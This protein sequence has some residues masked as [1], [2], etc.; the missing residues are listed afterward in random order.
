MSTTT[1]TVV[2]E[3][4]PGAKRPGFMVIFAILFIAGAAVVFLGTFIYFVNQVNQYK[5]ACTGVKTK[6][7]VTGIIM[8]V[9]GA[10]LVLAAIAFLIFY[11][12]KTKSPE[13]VAASAV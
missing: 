1:G 3:K 12:V 7:S 11:I 5:K 4:V 2:Q 9:V 13:G 6:P 8:W 10:V